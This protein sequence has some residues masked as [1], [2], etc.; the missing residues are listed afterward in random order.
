MKFQ[1]NDGGRAAAGFAGRA[2]DCVVR[3]IAI[4]TQKPYAEI[5]AAI[6]HLADNEHFD[7][8][9]SEHGVKRGLW[10]PYLESLGWKWIPTMKIGQGCKTHLRSGELPQGRII[11]RVS[12]HLCA[13]V[14]GV[15]N[16]THDCSRD[17]SRCV[18]GYWIKEVA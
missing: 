8:S 7:G 3:A 12:R 11:A 2:S 17:G 14:D 10:Q 18:Y 4:A 13:V 6:N 5:H 9:D 1:Y 16:D 15:L